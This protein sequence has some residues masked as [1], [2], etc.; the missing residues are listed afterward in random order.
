[1]GVLQLKDSLYSFSANI[2]V[3]SKL[4]SALFSTTAVITD[5]L[6]NFSNLSR[7]TFS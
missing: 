4:L 6:N 5:L 3:K 2:S 1:M 7:Y